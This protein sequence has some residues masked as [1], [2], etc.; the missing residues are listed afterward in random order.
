MPSVLGKLMR[1]VLPVGTLLENNTGWNDH[2]WT[3]ATKG[4]DSLNAAPPPTTFTL[5]RYVSTAGSWLFTQ[6]LCSDACFGL[7][8]HYHPPHNPPKC[9][10]TATRA[11]LCTFTHTHHFLKMYRGFAQQRVVDLLPCAYYNLQLVQPELS[12]CVCVSA[13]DPQVCLWNSCLKSLEYLR[14]SKVT[15]A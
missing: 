6:E 2:T 1:S 7:S 8:P 13:S 5:L 4:E 12:I 3:F 10:H 14:R 15:V 9:I 11:L